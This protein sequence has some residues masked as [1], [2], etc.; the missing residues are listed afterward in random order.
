MKNQWGWGGFTAHSIAQTA[1][2]AGL[3]VIAANLSNIF[4]RLGGDGSHRETATSRP[5]LQSCIALPHAPREAGRH[6]HLHDR[7]RKGAGNLPRDQRVPREG[8]ICVAV[9][10][11]ARCQLIVAYA[12]RKYGIV[13]RLFPP[14]IGRQAPLP[15]R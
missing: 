15:L 7:E 2:F 14:L 1:L 8:R 11:R 5:L 12:L 4:T 13:R 9:G 10:R 6:N 3:S